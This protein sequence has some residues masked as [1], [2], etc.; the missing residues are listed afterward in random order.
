MDP[1]SATSLMAR[2]SEVVARYSWD[3]TADRTL[4][5]LERLVPR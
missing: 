5:H 3:T 4:D 2:A 1:A